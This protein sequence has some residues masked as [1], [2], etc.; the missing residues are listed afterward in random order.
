LQAQPSFELGIDALDAIE[1]P[2]GSTEEF[3]ADM[4]L[5]SAGI[6]GDQGPQGWS[7]GV[8]NEGVDI[9]EAT[10]AG[11]AS[12]DVNADPPGLRNTGFEISEV[13][14]PAR[15]DGKQGI[16]S[17]V[18]LSFI[19]PVT[20]PA[21]TV[22]VIA[23]GRYLATIGDQGQARIAFADGLVGGGQPVFNTITFEGESRTPVLGEK[24]IAITPPGG[25]DLIL[26]GAGGGT[27][28]EDDLNVM[29]VPLA[30]D[31]PFELELF[32]APSDPTHP[33]EEG[34]AGW[35]VGIAH[36]PA[37]LAV[38]D[39]D[40]FPTIEDTRAA[41]LFEATGFEK[42]EVVDPERNGGRGGVVSAVVLSFVNRVALDP[43]RAEDIL[44]A[45]YTITEEGV[46][47]GEAF[48]ATV[49]IEDGLRGSG[50]PVDI[51]LTIAG[52]SEEPARR[53]GVKVL[54]SAV[55]PEDSFRRG[56]A[57]DDGRF[58][59]TDAVW[60]IR[61]VIGSGPAT[62][63]ADAA[64]ANDDGLLDLSDPMYLL[65]FLFLAGPPPPAPYP[66]CGS[67]L[68]ADALRC[69]LQSTQQCP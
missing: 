63:C 10:T 11:T 2:T 59:V 68:T 49:A 60:I 25:L 33:L 50:Q 37:L 65:E 15:N 46:A 56:D 35:S 26:D 27:T 38:V 24:L 52:I 67:D 57:N 54:G 1:G 22:Q 17:A 53:I 61:G 6:D 40:S 51:V 31:A 12:A 39:D 43:A 32:V 47:A 48:E 16:V 64:D 66:D 45:R 7:V 23:R 20:L 69:P 3:T 30:L 36:D 19:M 58:N 34:A 9:L 44:R 29:S 14:D 62:A 55:E 21:N 5:T 41:E 18:V 42:T 4:T 13:I 28:R 8:L